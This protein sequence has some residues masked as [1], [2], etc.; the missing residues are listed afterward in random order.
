[1]L[2]PSLKPIQ[3]FSPVASAEARLLILGSMPGEA[4]LQAGQYYAHSRNAFWPLMGN[5]LGF[6]PETHYEERL[7]H[8]TEHKIALWD[9][10]ES[11]TRE[12]SL[13]SAIRREIPNDLP[14]FLSRHPQ[15]RTIVF[16]GQKAAKSCCK[17]F[18]KLNSTYQCFS[19]PSTSPANA[20][21]PYE[22]KCRAWKERL[23]NL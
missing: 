23:L 15:I 6:S 14:G 21:I 9:V 8:L 22:Q 17:H 7:N 19:L 1:M 3:S 16:N 10:L 2:P 18:P 5:I 4:S 20:S 13:D 11:C 12:G